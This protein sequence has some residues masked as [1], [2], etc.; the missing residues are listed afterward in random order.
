MFGRKNNSTG[1]EYGSRVFIYAF[2]IC[3]YCIGS[4]GLYRKFDNNLKRESEYWKYISINRRIIWTSRTHPI[5][6]WTSQ[7]AQ[8]HYYRTAGS[9]VGRIFLKKSTEHK[10]TRK[11]FNCLLQTHRCTLAYVQVSDRCHTLHFLSQS[12]HMIVSASQTSFLQYN[13]HC[14]YYSEW[15]RYRGAAEK[16]TW[17]V[18]CWRR[19]D[20]KERLWPQSEQVGWGDTC[21]SPTTGSTRPL[22]PRSSS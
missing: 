14:V 13:K 17:E 6:P 15:H 9:P 3:A 10:Q 4:K 11:I 21:T 1:G 22:S 5:L 8:C 20:H 16:L 12:G 18:S 7:T 2:I 19:P